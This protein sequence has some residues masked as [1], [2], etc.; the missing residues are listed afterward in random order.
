[1]LVSATGR[2]KPARPSRSPASRTSAKRR[3]PG[4]GAAGELRIGGEQGGPQLAEGPAAQ[5]H[6][7]EKAVG[8]ERLARLNQ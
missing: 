4:A 6:R 2:A 5:H 1:M 8:L 3:Y 7:Q